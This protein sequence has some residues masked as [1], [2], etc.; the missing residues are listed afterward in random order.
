MENRTEKK[1]HKNTK[2][3]E[4]CFY[5][6][7]SVC[8][9]DQECT[10][11][12]SLE[13]KNSRQICPN[14]EKTKQCFYECPLR[15]CTFPMTKGKSDEYCF[16]EN[17]ETGCTKANCEFRHKRDTHN[18]LLD[19]K[20]EYN[21][22]LAKQEFDIPDRNFVEENRKTFD[23]I[24]IANKPW[25]NEKI[26]FS[27]GKSQQPLISKRFSQASN[28]SRN[29]RINYEELIK[30]KVKMSEEKFYETIKNENLFLDSKIREIEDEIDN[31]GY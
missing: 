9:K 28:D 25:L 13:A 2:Q 18:S 29:K 4:D 12:H 24:K 26:D 30:S 8:K 17:T 16:F 23:D 14:W 20:E 22:I 15:H 7:Q 27:D 11:R 21:K 19:L 6:M 1:S 5:F 3:I 10:F 31:F